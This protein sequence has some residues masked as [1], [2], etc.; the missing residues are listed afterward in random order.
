MPTKLPDKKRPL[1]TKEN[2]LFI[3]GIAIIVFELISAE[4]LGHAYHYE[5]LLLGAALCGVAGTQL[6]DRSGK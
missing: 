4:V 2:V 6:G 1:F 3:L 5:F